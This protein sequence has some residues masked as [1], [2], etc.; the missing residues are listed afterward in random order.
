VDKNTEKNSKIVILKTL[1]GSHAHG[2]ADENSDRDYRSVY[3]EPTKE[4]LSLGHR[5]KGS[6]WLEGNEDNTSYEIGHFLH[7]ATKSNP[8]ILEIFKA[9]IVFSNDYGR[10]L[11]DLFPHVW[12]ANDA[13]N[14]F[15]GY[16]LNQRKK[17]LDKK[18]DR[19]NKY[20]VAYIRTLYNLI[21]LLSMGT[22][23]LDVTRNKYLFEMLIKYRRGE[24]TF[25]EIINVAEEFTER[26][27]QLLEKYPPVEKNIDEVNK[28]LVEVRRRYWE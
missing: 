10:K 25:G 14:A 20:A 5:Y 3:V 4:I 28:F 2:L 12:N 11:R 1:V 22:F 7:L 16:G 26:A 13:F 27:R 21:D 6:S 24:Y 8:T 19:Q 9:P 18:D 15:V 23:D 17:F